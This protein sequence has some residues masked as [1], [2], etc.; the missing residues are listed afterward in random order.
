MEEREFNLWRLLEII[1]RRMKF[2]VVFVVTV[3]IVSVI[4]S[5]LLPKWYKASALI[6]PPKEDTMRLGTNGVE[7]MVSLTAGLVLPGRATPSDIYA[8]ILKS[9]NMFERVIEANKLK[10]YYHISSST[11]LIDEI[12]K[13]AEFRVTEEG[14]LEITYIDKNPKMAAEIANSFVEE[15]DVMSR[16]LSTSR[17]KTTREFIGNRLDEVSRDLDSSRSALNEFQQKYK[18]IDLDRQTQLAIESAVNLKVSLAE[19]EIDLKI[20]EK[21]LSPSHPDV[22]TLQRKVDEIKS[23]IK[24]LEEGT[25]NGSYLSLP[26]SEVPYLKSKLAELTG[27][28]QLSQTLFEVLSQQYEQAKIQ[29]KMDTPVISILDKAYPP[30][31]AFK[32]QKRIIVTVSTVLAAIVAV[33][34]ALF[35]HYISE[36]RKNSPRDYDRARLFLGTILGW[37]PGLGRLRSAGSK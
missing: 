25:E 30:E 33:F 35:M 4:V 8:R 13:H 23:Q 2:I 3:A 15:L 5:L 17:A 9:R 31:I 32:P 12:S 20:K 36:L 26:V 28:V 27:K 11:D 34:M 37:I 7:D 29:E 14:L 22:I 18:A 21:S 24:S 6:L 19:N 16:E 1:A 10:D